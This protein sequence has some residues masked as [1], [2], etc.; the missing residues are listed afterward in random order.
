MRILDYLMMLVIVIS[1]IYTSY[2]FGV[3]S[4]DIKPTSDFVEINGTMGE[5]RLSKRSIYRIKQITDDYGTSY[6]VSFQS[7][8]GNTII[9]FID[10]EYATAKEDM[11]SF[12]MA[13]KESL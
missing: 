5:F 9:E 10:T 7:I 13:F 11:E 12:L 4:V 3:N 8:E 2:T 6:Y 1:T